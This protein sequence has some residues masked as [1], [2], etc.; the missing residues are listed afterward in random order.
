MILTTVTRWNGNRTG[1]EY[2]HKI[3][4]TEL[5]PSEPHSAKGALME[6]VLVLCE[7]MKQNT[8]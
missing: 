7:P 5:W 8:Q 1:A 4:R 3:G 6:P 2:E